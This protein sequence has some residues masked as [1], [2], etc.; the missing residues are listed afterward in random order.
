M[1]ITDEETLEQP[2]VEAA[3]EVGE[4]SG[5]ARGGQ[6][7]VG[8]GPS[9]GTDRRGL[10]PDKAGTAGADPVPSPLGQVGRFTVVIAVPTFHGQDAEAVADEA[11]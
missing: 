3:A 1:A 11:A 10:T 9:F 2:A 7:L 6:Q 5:V 4:T 8:V